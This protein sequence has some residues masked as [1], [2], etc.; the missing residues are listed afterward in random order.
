M[1]Y[2]R[3]GGGNSDPAAGSGELVY[4]YKKFICNELNE[5]DIYA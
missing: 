1:T 5:V 2:K 3:R 4:S